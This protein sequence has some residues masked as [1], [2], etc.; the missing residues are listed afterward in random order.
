M[1]K[2][3]CSQVGR[4]NYDVV[5]THLRLRRE[6]ERAYMTDKIEELTRSR[7]MGGIPDP[8]RG[9]RSARRS[10]LAEE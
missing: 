4:A 6:E 3:L 5:K 7:C 9:G 2:R 8:L 1:Q 10:A